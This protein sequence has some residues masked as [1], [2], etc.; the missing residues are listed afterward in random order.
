MNGDFSEF[1]KLSETQQKDCQSA[2]NQDMWLKY[3][4]SENAVSED[5]LYKELYDIIDKFEK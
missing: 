3:M 5:D 4:A 1:N 2:W